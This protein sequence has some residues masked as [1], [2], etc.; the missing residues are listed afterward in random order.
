MLKRIHVNM[1]VI[2][3][4]HRDGTKE[5]PLS[6]KARGRTFRAHAIEIRGPA[7]VIYA[8]DKPLQCGAR[9]WIETRAPVLLVDDD[10]EPIDLA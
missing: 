2:R 4:N 3:R 5:A 1:H 9:V 6:V 7:T 8:P 10:A